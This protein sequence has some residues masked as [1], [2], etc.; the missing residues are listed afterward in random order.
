MR[1]RLYCGEPGHY[2]ASCPIPKRVSLVAYAGA[3]TSSDY[4][5]LS[6]WIMF[7]STLM[8]Q[9]DS[10]DSDVGNSFFFLLCCSRFRFNWAKGMLTRWSFHCL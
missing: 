3:L 4:C 6:S 7:H 8:C 10:P 9:L 1:G 2:I 5:S